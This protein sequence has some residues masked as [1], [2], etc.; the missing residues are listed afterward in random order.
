[1]NVLSYGS[2][3]DEVLEM[4]Q[5]LA[6]SGYTDVGQLDGRFGPLTQAALVRFQTDFGLAADGVCGDRTWAMLRGGGAHEQQAEW[7]AGQPHDPVEE[8]GA[9]GPSGEWP[10]E[11]PLEP[12]DG[13][14]AAGEA[15]DEGEEDLAASFEEGDEQLEVADAEEDDDLLGVSEIAMADVAKTA[16]D[17]IA[18]G[19]KAW[20]LIKNKATVSGPD[21]HVVHV[22]PAGADLDN[23]FDGWRGT[24]Y[25]RRRY[26][27][28]QRGPRTFGRWDTATEM[29][30]KVMFTPF[31]HWKRGRHVNKGQFLKDIRVAVES[32]RFHETDVDVSVRFDDPEPYAV[33]ARNPISKINVHVVISEKPRS[34]DALLSTISFE[35][36]GNGRAKQIGDTTSYRPPVRVKG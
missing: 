14:G 9:A 24:N 17:I 6:N 29:W 19:D 25:I 31:G 1:M 34:G 22:I 20:D 36:W 26:V 2:E 30:I 16:S 35:L 18:V 5:L 3:G 10:G 7:P 27:S 4:Q 23:D 15:G 32:A 11:Q 21:D 28:Q 33:S 13:G 12:A 8:G